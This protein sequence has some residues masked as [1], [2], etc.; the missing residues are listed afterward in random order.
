MPVKN[1]IAPPK[2][3]YLACSL[4]ARPDDT[5]SRGGLDLAIFRV[6]GVRQNSQLGSLEYSGI[7]QAIQNISALAGSDPP[8]FL[9]QVM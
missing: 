1:Y 6:L 8:S 5:S 9:E 7:N 2:F 3:N 4:L